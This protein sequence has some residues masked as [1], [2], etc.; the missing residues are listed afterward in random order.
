MGKLTSFQYAY[1]A[2]IIVVFRLITQNINISFDDLFCNETCQSEKYES[3]DFWDKHREEV[4]RG[5]KLL[6]GAKTYTDPYTGKTDWN[7]MFKD[8]QQMKRDPFT[9]F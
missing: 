9:N 7:S 1:I 4:R 3:S 8:Q 5:R 2:I 6:R